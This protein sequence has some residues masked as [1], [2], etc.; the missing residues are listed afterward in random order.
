VQ[1]F[2]RPFVGLPNGF[3]PDY[4]RWLDERSQ[5]LFVDDL[6]SEV[7]SILNIEITQNIVDSRISAPFA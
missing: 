7:N 4:V 6:N 1:H 3:G 5:R 2:I